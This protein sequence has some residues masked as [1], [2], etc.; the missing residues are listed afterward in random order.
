MK[1]DYFNKNGLF[2]RGNSDAFDNGT[3]LF[4]TGGAVHLRKKNSYFGLLKN[5]NTLYAVPMPAE[6]GQKTYYQGIG[7]GEAYAV[8]KG[9]PNAKAVPYFLRYFL[10]G[11]NYDLNTYFCNKQNLE[12]YNWCMN[13]K[14]RVF[15][16]TYYDYTSGNQNNGLDY[17]TTAQ[18]KKYIDANSGTVDR[19]VKSYNDTLAKLK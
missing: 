11:A 14:N 2:V 1:Y 5:A 19:E 15:F 10:D 6:K 9:A 16:Y 18:V 12:V 17:Q 7:E 13:Q 8:V 3:L 4:C